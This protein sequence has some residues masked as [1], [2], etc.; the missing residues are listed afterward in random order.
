M[1]EPCISLVYVLGQTPPTWCSKIL[2]ALYQHIRLSL[3]DKN[4]PDT[5]ACRL[6]LWLSLRG[7][8]LNQIDSYR[9][10]FAGC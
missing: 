1:I 2:D 9:F 7:M 3:I 10:D 8:I 5:L 6:T 4:G